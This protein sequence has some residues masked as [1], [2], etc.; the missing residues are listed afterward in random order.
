MCT[1]DGTLWSL[2]V[3]SVYI[4]EKK[5]VIPSLHKTAMMRERERAVSY[6]FQNRNLLFFFCILLCHLAP[7]NGKEEK[8]PVGHGYTI[9]SVAVHPSG[10]SLTAHLGLI[11][12]SSIFGP[13]IKNLNFIA[14]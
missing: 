10:K 12:G 3:F 2:V 4:N 1:C 14:R 9:R 13:D 8:E 11:K 7:V 5:H 6:P